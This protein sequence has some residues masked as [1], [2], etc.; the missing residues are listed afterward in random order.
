MCEQD[1]DSLLQNSLPE[2]P[3]DDVVA[4]VTPWR[5]AMNRALFGLALTVV[6]LNFWCLN[7][8]LPAIGL[9]LSLLGFRTLRREN[10]WFKR[11]YV[12]T[13][14]RAAYFF[15]TLILNATIYQSAAY[16]TPLFQGLT[17]LSLALNFVL[18][19]CLRQGFRAV[20]Q[21]AG[22][23]AH[24]G[25]AT[26]LMI[27]YALL[28]A[29]ALLQYEGL[30]IAGF[31]IVA[32]ICIIRNLFQLSKELDEA[33]YAIQAAPV[34]VPDRALAVGIAAA[35]LIGIACA[36]LFGSRYPMA[37]TPVERT[38]SE[39]A[40]AIREN[41]VS[42]GFPEAILD[43]LTEDDL[44]AC[45]GAQRVLVQTMDHSLHDDEPYYKITLH[46]KT[47]ELR[48]T[49]VAVQLPGTPERWK[50]FH[51]FQ[52]L[53][54]PGF[55]G[56]ESIQLWPAYSAS[57]AWGAAGNVT[58]QVLYDRDGQTFAAPYYELG[59]Q[60]YTAESVF[61]GEQ[62]RTDMFAAF[63]LPS[64]GGNQ[65]GYLSYTIQK[66][67]DVL[68]I[69]SFANYTHQQTWL[70]YPAL[71]AKEQRMRNIWSTGVFHTVQGELQIWL[72]KNLP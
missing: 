44:M 71:T 50:V 24:T 64:A 11:C 67:Q 39:Q 72:D 38:G 22:L 26:A 34:R 63:S 41:L 57:D 68:V 6:T 59:A 9:I 2:L 30:I 46:E 31:L 48:F 18:I 60:T 19:I 10:G 47:D 37:W 7:Y 43:D 61:F 29:L 62:N 21:K 66:L 53:A 58:G 12:L 42:L 1:F 56:T 4:E 25:G 36:F 14:I 13:L 17:A 8:I 55:Y 27:W 16:S 20:Q 52:W 40:D 32:Y 35:L 49:G 5:S 69:D 70:Q 54:D 28:C 23:P 45:A 33:G 3:P 65:R 51:H 15:P